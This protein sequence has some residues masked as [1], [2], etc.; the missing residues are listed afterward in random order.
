MQALLD[1]LVQQSHYAE[2][3][4]VLDINNYVAENQTSIATMFEEPDALHKLN[5]LLSEI[6]SPILEKILLLK[7]DDGL[8][9]MSYL[10]NKLFEE[11]NELPYV[12]AYIN[13]CSN[14]LD[15][16]LN[17]T[18]DDGR[19][20][21][22]FILDPS[23][24][25]KPKY[26]LFINSLSSQIKHIGSLL[27]EQHWVKILRDLSRASPEQ[28]KEIKAALLSKVAPGNNTVLAI[29]CKK[30]KIS[31]KNILDE[32]SP[33]DW[34]ALSS[35]KI[36]DNNETLFDYLG[37]DYLDARPSDQVTHP[38]KREYYYSVCQ[39]YMNHLKTTEFDDVTKSQKM[40][41][42]KINLVENAQLALS[43]ER[44]GDLTEFYRVLKQP[45]LDS[46]YDKRPLLSIS[47]DSWAM[48]FLKTVSGF[49]LGISMY[50][51]MF[52]KDKTIEGKNV[53]DQLTATPPKP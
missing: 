45:D 37:A 32:L 6:K 5:V 15:D 20:F 39:K 29:I 31:L 9:V 42:K 52:R 10:V 43:Q 14:N 8:T 41:N 50:Y 38:F 51:S 12:L 49:N 27:P 53:L 25:G 46:K 48:W 34:R 19:T 2:D 16:I 35:E 18:G 28:K 30:D 11:P 33:E 44:N 40:T 36:N 3:Q 23:Q 26:Y 17:T 24:D 22:D 4:F 13:N 21:L 47:R 7:G 1:N